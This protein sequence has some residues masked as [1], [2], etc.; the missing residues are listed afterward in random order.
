[1][2]SAQWFVGIDWASDAHVV[3]VLDREGRLVEEGRRV[4]HT[5]AGLRA[6][7]DTVLARGG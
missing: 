4:E 5:A 2:L 7:V 3:S 1:M 6:W